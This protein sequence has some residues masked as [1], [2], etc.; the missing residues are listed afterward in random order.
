M[1]DRLGVALIREGERTGK[2]KPG[3]T[4]IEP[5]AGNTGIGI[6]LAA[7]GTD[8]RV[9]FVVPEKFSVEKQELMRALGAEVI[10]TPT[11]LGMKGAMEKAKELE[12]S[13]PELKAN[14]AAPFSNSAIS[15]SNAARVGFPVREYS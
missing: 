13:I 12:Q 2:L 7:V 14:P 9:I 11:E 8:Y 15:C 6:A 4:I 1:K 10:N 3:G 5:T